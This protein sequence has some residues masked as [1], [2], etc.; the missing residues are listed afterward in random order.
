MKLK[1]LAVVG[2]VLFALRYVFMSA[3]VLLGARQEVL[4]GESYTWPPAVIA[5]SAVVLCLA[6]GTLLSVFISKARLRVGYVLAAACLA[7]LAAIEARESLV[8]HVN[9]GPIPIG[10][11]S[12]YIYGPLLVLWSLL[13]AFLAVKAKG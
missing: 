4:S 2:N 5:T 1:Y 9:Y 10:A 12:E 6:I 13:N 8:L 3:W 7:G 11:V